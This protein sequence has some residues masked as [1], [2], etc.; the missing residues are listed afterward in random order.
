MCEKVIAA[1]NHMAK[2]KLVPG[3]VHAAHWLTNPGPGPVPDI[4]RLQPRLH[5]QE[6]RRRVVAALSEAGTENVSWDAGQRNR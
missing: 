2:L 3:R 4:P 1:N 6:R 5:A